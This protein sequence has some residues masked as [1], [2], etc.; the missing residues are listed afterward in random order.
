MRFKGSVDVPINDNGAAARFTVYHKEIDG[1]VD[2]LQASAQDVADGL[3]LPVAPAGFYDGYKLGAQE[4]TGVAGKVILASD[5]VFSAS[6]GFDYTEDRSTHSPI[7]YQGWGLSVPAPAG[8]ISTFSS[9]GTQAVQLAAQ[10]GCLAGVTN[11][12]N[13]A[14]DAI[15]QGAVT[16]PT[17]QI[18]YLRATARLITTRPTSLSKIVM[19]L[20]FV[21]KIRWTQGASL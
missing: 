3:T 2:V 19:A 18:V 13:A 12:A 17:I 14:R 4:V 1:F 11:N 5:D 15:S 16:D 20:G 9:V 21:R 7:S 10:F 8:D 6:V